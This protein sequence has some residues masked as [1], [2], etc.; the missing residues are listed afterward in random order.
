M[1]DALIA[2]RGIEL[3]SD[4]LLGRTYYTIALIEG[5]IAPNVVSPSAIAELSFRTSRPADEVLQA[6][7]PLERTVRLEEVLRVADVRF[8]TFDDLGL[9]SWLDTLPNGLET[10]VGER[11]EYLSVG[12]RQL[13]SLAR[14]Y[15]SR[16]SCLILDEATSAVDPATEVT[17]ARAVDSLTAGRTT[18]AIAHRLSTAERADLVLV[19]DHGRLVDLFAHSDRLPGLR[20]RQPRP[21]HAR[22]RQSAPTSIPTITVAIPATCK[23][24]TRSPSRS[25][26]QNTPSA[27]TSGGSSAPRDGPRAA[28]ARL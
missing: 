25:Q 28:T 26:A 22:G 6:V 24:E 14:A 4:P 1:I 2:L 8:H 5:G 13:V 3:P 11:G 20:V 12:E 23:A 15:L 9:A 27:G 17:L 21:G 19:M 7:R 16:P 18:I 10:R